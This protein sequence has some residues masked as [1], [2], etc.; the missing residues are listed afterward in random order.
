MLAH[1]FWFARVDAHEFELFD[2]M[3]FIIATKLQLLDLSLL[4]R[5]LKNSYHNLFSLRTIIHIQ[6]R[7]YV[8]GSSLF[9]LFYIWNKPCLSQRRLT[10]QRRS[11]YE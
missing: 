1:D 8:H 2:K 9:N 7:E 10:V 4:C 11:L 3:Q 6:I 5:F